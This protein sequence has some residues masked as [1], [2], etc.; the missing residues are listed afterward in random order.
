[1]RLIAFLLGFFWTLQAVASSPSD[2]RGFGQK[3]PVQLYLFTS[4]TCPYCANFHKNVFPSILKEYVDTGKAQLIIVDVIRGQRDMLGTSAVRCLSGKKADKLE[5]FLYENQQKLRKEEIA[6]VKKTIIDQVKKDNVKETEIKHCMNDSEL[7]KSITDQQ[8]NLSKLYDVG[9]V[10]A[11]V[12]RKGL[13]IH[14]WSGANK[15]EIMAG[16]K[17]ALEE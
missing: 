12:V 11:L 7:Q 8:E 2:L 16:L 9:G 1:M 15:K 13:E 10:P 5:N 3:A 14:K 17:E 4:L 6:E